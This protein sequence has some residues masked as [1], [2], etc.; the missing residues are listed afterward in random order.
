MH[1][2][3]IWILKVEII[4]TASLSLKA[5]HARKSSI[6]ASGSKSRQ[7]LTRRF[8]YLT[9]D[10]HSALPVRICAGIHFWGMRNYTNR[11]S[12][13][14]FH[15]RFA[16]YALRISVKEVIDLSHFNVRKSY[17][18]CTAR[19]YRDTFTI[20]LVYDES[21]ILAAPFLQVFYCLLQRSILSYD[22]S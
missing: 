15:A 22:R 14:L 16:L 17:P 21:N 2:I 18:F 7:S 20:G 9:Y 3:A 11:I 4:R 6:V 5:I 13:V 8:V 1:K 10:A 12:S 19:S